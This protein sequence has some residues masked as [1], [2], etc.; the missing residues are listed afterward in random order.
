MKDEDKTSEQLIAELSEMRKKVSDLEFTEKKRKKTEDALLAARIHLERIVNGM[1]EGM[2]VI[3]PGYHVLDANERFYEMTGKTLQQVIGKP[4]YQVN[5]NAPKPCS[6]EGLDCPLKVV[7]QTGKPAR[8]EVSYKGKHGA[9]MVVETNTFPLIDASGGIESVVQISNDITERMRSEE[10]LIRIKHAVDTSSDAIGMSTKEGGHFYQ[11]E[12]F[13]RLFGYTVEEVRNLHPKALYADGDI[14]NEVFKTI[15]EGG[16]WSHGID[17]VTKDGRIF[18]VSLRANAI[19]DKYG[20]ILGLIGVHRDITERKQAEEVLKHRVDFISL[21][22]DLSTNFIN[23]EP[24]NVDGAINKALGRIGEFFDADRNYVF[25]FSED[26][27]L[28]SNTHEWCAEGVEPQIDYLQGIPTANSQGWME[29]LDRMENI[30]I[31]SVADMPNDTDTGEKEVLEAQG[32]QSLLIVPIAVRGNTIGFLGLDSVQNPHIYSDDDIALLG[33]AGDIFA[34]ALTHKQAEEMLRES[35]EKFSK[36]FQSNAAL[37]AISTIDNGL[38]FEVNDMFLKTLEFE[39]EEV[40]GATSVDLNIWANYDQR[41][42]VVTSMQEN[43]YV[44]NVDVD[45]RTKSGKIRNGLFSAHPLELQGRKCLLTI[46]SDITERKLVQEKLEQ[47]Q[48]HLEELVEERTAELKAAQ[49]KLLQQERLATLGELAGSISH[50][51]R[52]PLGVIDSSVYFLTKTHLPEIDEKSKEH[53][54]R[55]RDAIRAST[56]IIESLLNLTRMDLGW[57]S[58]NGHIVKQR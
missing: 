24:G 48:Q 52:N 27:T 49:E 50:E 19:K 33:I 44:Q 30:N 45:I 5:R 57:S 7:V 31:P 15:M 43:G 47:Y 26:K 32:I 3:S 11:N 28:Q 56:G 12:A 42:E 22:T 34:N 39:R 54:D 18:P 25:L 41:A 10:E 38:F 13:T 35:E 17:M 9:D 37:M 2:L 8:M 4:C 20:N 51:I 21:I 53:F 6:E 23:L 40:I 58:P 46:M 14:A 29:A 16:S 36:S 55:I 1:H